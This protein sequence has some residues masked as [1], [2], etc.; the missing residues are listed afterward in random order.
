MNNHSTNKK[1]NSAGAFLLGIQRI[2]AASLLYSFASLFVLVFVLATIISTYVIPAIIT[3]I[4]MVIPFQ[5]VCAVF[6]AGNTSFAFTMAVV[7][8][9][10]AYFVFDVAIMKCSQAY[11]AYIRGES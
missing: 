9:C 1:N 6:L 8:I 10:I 4:I 11:Y 5:K 3:L 7:C 2:I